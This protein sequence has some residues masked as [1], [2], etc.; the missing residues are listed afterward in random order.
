M[1]A[2]ITFTEGLASTS[3]LILSQT[4]YSGLAVVR[5]AVDD[6]EAVLFDLDGVLIDSSIVVERHWRRWAEGRGIDF[7][8]VRAVMHGRTSAEIVAL[9]APHLDAAREGRQREAG[10]GVD[11]DGLRVFEGAAALLSALPPHRWGVVTSGNLLTATTRLRFGG[12]PAPATLVTADDVQRGKPHPEAYLLAAGRLGVQPAA[13]AVVEDAPAGIAA[14]VAAGMR[15]IAVTTTHRP[16]DLSTA[17]LIVP[18]VRDLAC[19]S[20]GGRMALGRRS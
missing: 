15:A 6:V 17:H 3:G 5:H 12:F 4:L 8:R 2:A 20:A 18:G 7:A 10:E 16:E 11:R 14:A 9:V 19:Q 1:A 13:C